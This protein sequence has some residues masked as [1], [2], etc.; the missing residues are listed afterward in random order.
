MSSTLRWKEGSFG[1]HFLKPRTYNAILS[2]K[3]LNNSLRFFKCTNMLK[4]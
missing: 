2:S 3:V 4:I 1:Q